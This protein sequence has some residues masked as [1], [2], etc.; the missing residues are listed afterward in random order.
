[1]KES[2]YSRLISAIATFIESRKLDGKGIV[3]VPEAEAGFN[4]ACDF[5]AHE[6]RMLEQ[7]GAR[8]ISAF[9]DKEQP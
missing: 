3:L 8:E 7:R 6:L 9:V 5:L 2:E 4:M 1:M